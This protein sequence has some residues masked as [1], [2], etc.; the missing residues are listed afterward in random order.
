ME[1]MILELLTDTLL[2]IVGVIL[3]GVV[4][5]VAYQV[6]KWLEIDGNAKQVKLLEEYAQLAVEAVE[7]GMSHLSGKEKYNNAKVKI[8]E[9]AERKN[10]P[11]DAEEIDSLIEGFT[12]KIKDEGREIKWTYD[13]E[14][15]GIEDDQTGISE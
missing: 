3:G 15:G 8:V 13:M 6:K 5:W 14:L 7:L 10:I 12:K 11:V 9:W 2:Q 4:T 1:A